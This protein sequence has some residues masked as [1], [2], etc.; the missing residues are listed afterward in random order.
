MPSK[1]KT[2][3]V[4]DLVKLV[5]ARNKKSTCSPD[6]RQGWNSMLEDV[7]HSTGNYQGYGYYT[8]EDL[9]EGQ[10]PGVRY[11][12][13]ENGHPI[14]PCKDYAERFRNCDASRRYYFL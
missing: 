1:R 8:V 12:Y 6:I 11:D 13:D 3:K 10:A 5:N 4:E 14:Q 2:V 7:L 9:P